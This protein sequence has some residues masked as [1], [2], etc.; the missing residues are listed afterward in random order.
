MEPEKLA[1]FRTI[2]NEEMRQLLQEA[3]TARK[4]S[5]RHLKL[6]T[7]YATQ[8]VHTGSL[9]STTARGGQHE[10][11]LGSTRHFGYCVPPPLRSE[12]AARP[13]LAGMAGEPGF[14]SLKSG[15]GVPT[16]APVDC[17]T[18]RTRR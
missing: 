11:Q 5:Q 6:L 17:S 14:Q 2:L 15:Y 13:P 9:S 18:A 7:V 1:Y 10:K 8:Q 12:D 16:C 4:K 3:A